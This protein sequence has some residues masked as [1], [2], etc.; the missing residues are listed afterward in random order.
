MRVMEGLIQPYLEY[1]L[2]NPN[3]LLA[4]IYGLF[5]IKTKYFIKL[6]VMVMQNT[7]IESPNHRNAIKFDLKGSRD[8]RRSK[9]VL[10]RWSMGRV[11]RAKTEEE[12]FRCYETNKIL[13]DINFIQINDQVKRIQ[14]SATQSAKTSSDPQ[15]NG[16]VCLSEHDQKRICK[17]ISKDADFLALYNL[18]DYSVFLVVEHLETPKD[19]GD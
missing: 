10:S 8:G 16:L 6:N 18:M 2:E 15:P 11:E 17:Q 4:R 19:T 9:N 7:F 14:L 12:F 13:K 1:L 5:T 3:S